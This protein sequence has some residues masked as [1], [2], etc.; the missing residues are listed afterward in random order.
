[1]DEKFMKSNMQQISYFHLTLPRHLSVLT[2]SSIAQHENGDFRRIKG[3]LNLLK[4]GYPT[5]GYRLNVVKGR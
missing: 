4:V 1:M 5:L 3:G 2:F